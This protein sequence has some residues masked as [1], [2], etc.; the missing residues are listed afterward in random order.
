MKKNLQI[1]LG[2]LLCL[3][4]CIPQTLAAQLL[5]LGSGKQVEILSAGPIL[6]GDGKSALVLQYRTQLS[7]S[8]LAALRKEADEVWNHFV[9]DV[10]KAHYAQ[11]AINAQ[12][13]EEGTLIKEGR[14]YSFLYEKQGES[15]RTS[16]G[17]HAAPLKLDEQNVTEFINRLDWLHDHGEG[18][19]LL[20]YLADDWTGTL[21]G[22][23][24]PTTVNRL[25]LAQDAQQSM[26]AIED[27]HHQRDIT[28]VTVSPDGRSAQVD[29]RETETGIHDFTPINIRETSSDVFEVRGY[30]I[31]WTKSQ[32]TKEQ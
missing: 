15:W 6:F 3:C 31:L 9:V 10:E 20:L 5:T 25:Q 4:F 16:E 1:A 14:L 22:P 11:A 29:S 30:H 26:G 28:K 8:D 17:N 27:Y 24:G 23:E 7:M 2:A 21:P 32:T 18:N 12:G 13:P 19:A